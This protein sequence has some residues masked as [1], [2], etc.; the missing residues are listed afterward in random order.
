M[1]VF[2][3]LFMVYNR[4]IT[5]LFF[6]AFC[7]AL[8]ADVDCFHLCFIAA[9]MIDSFFCCY[10]VSSLTSSFNDSAH[11]VQLIVTILLLAE[12]AVDFWRW[13]LSGPRGSSAENHVSE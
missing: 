10:W 9:M 1:D 2:Q 3:I 4:A 13:L 7:A 5:L 6:V 12:V 8:C 11:F